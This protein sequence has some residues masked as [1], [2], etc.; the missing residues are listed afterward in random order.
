V[1]NT[2]DMAELWH[3]RMAHLHHGG[4]KVL[5]EIVTCLLDFNT[6]HHE[7]CKG[8]AMGKYTKT[9]FPSRDNKT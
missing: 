1:S 5:K 3:R 7:V 4:L 8:Y 9:T 2:C 6:E